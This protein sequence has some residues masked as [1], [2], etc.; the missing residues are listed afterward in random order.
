MLIIWNCSAD[1]IYCSIPKNGSPFNLAVVVSAADVRCG[2]LSKA[3]HFIYPPSP[4]KLSEPLKRASCTLLTG[5]PSHRS[6]QV[7][8]FQPAC[9]QSFAARNVA[10]EEYGKGTVAPEL[11]WR[12]GFAGL[13]AAPDAALPPW[14]SW[15]LLPEPGQVSSA[16]PRWTNLS[17]PTRSTDME[18]NLEFKSGFSTALTKLEDT[19]PTD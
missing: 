17:I 16:R 9:E 14:F 18:V 10:G 11:R 3:P 6:D 7:T 4:R 19:F 2:Q 5:A 8:A 13:G 1:G 15:G 12:P